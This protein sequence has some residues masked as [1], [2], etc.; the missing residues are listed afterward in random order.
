MTS[1]IY[2]GTLP[3]QGTTF[4][5][6]PAVGTVVGSPI[7]TGGTVVGAPVTTYSSGV[8][9]ALPTTVVSSGGYGTGLVSGGVVSG[10]YVSGGVVSGGVVSGGV[11]STSEIIKGIL[12]F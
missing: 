4:V 10:G 1:T 11:V 9:G 3:Y 12:R 6:A 8:V 5:G 2:N 7:V